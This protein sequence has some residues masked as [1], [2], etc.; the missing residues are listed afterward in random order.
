MDYRNFSIDSKV[1]TARPG[2]LQVRIEEGFLCC[3][4][5]PP[6]GIV[7]SASVETKGNVM[8]VR[9]SYIREHHFLSGEA[10]S[11]KVW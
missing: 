10:T 11:D 4:T 2:G 3:V 7:Y 1:V 5:H 6:R 8:S 9:S